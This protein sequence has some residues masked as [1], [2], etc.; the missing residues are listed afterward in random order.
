[1]DL[2]PAHTPDQEGTGER[3]EPRLIFG[4]WTI[5]RA[6]MAGLGVSVL[7]HLV[8]LLIAL[9]VRFQPPPDPG[10]DGD[11]EPVEFAILPESA[12]EPVRA[13]EVPEVETESIES[14]APEELELLSDTGS[15]RSV[16]DLADEIAPELDAGG[17][18]ITD[19][20]VQAGSSGAGSGEGASFF[21]LE[22]TGRRF[23]YIVDRSG[24]MNSSMGAG[25]TTRW[26]RTQIEMIRSIR[27][28]GAGA[29]FF[30]MLYSSGAESLYGDTSWIDAERGRLSAASNAIMRLDAGGQTRPL[31]AFERVFRLEPRPD[32]IYFMT[33]GEFEAG[34]VREIER[35]NARARIPIHCIL[36]GR[37]ANPGAMRRVDAMMRN[38][39]RQSGGRYRHIVDGGMP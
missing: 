34:V 14:D 25:A 22:A 8:V 12:L 36:Y 9:V 37:L 24:S 20:D 17:G 30:I 3:D 28:L 31:L 19:T 13:V 33:D 2:R 21:G 5:E 15:D 23:A 27:G 11:A 26:E 6:T 38:I 16:S 35:M 32:A 39:A 4:R 29:R 18:S 10:G 1:M 7:V